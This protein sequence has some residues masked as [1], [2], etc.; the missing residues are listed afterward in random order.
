MDKGAWLQSMGS[1]TKKQQSVKNI[2][3]YN[4]IYY[5]VRPYVG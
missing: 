4:K 1:K 2:I 3:K 5:F